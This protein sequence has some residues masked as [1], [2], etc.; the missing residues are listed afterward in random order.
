MLCRLIAVGIITHV[1]HLHLRDFVDADAIVAV[2][3]DWRY[4]EHGIEH[5]P[6]FG[7]TAHQIGKSSDVV[8]HRPCVVPGIAFRIGIPPFVGAEWRLER[9]VRIPSPHQFRFGIEQISV[10]PRGFLQYPHIFGPAQQLRYLSD[11]PVI[12]GIFECAGHI[13]RDIHVIGNISQRVV[14]LMPPASRGAYRGMYLAASCK[15]RLIECRNV[16]LWRNAFQNGV[17]NHRGRV[18]AHHA[19]AVSGR[20]PFGQETALA[21]SIGQTCLYLGTDRRVNEIQQRKQTAERIP[22]SRIGVHV[23]GQYLSVIRAV[24]YRFALRI[25]F[26]KFAGEER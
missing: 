25:D 13:L 5:L 18:V 11:A 9:A 7:L 15:H 14:V 6:E 10:I 17:R 8:E 12:V 2:I 1:G 4:D 22:E 23:P 21:V 19:A 16:F 3:I 26:V 20:C 24:M